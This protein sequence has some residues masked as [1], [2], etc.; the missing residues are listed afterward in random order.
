MEF[1]LASIDIAGA[2]SILSI[3]L[4]LFAYL[5]TLLQYPGEFIKNYYVSMYYKI[6]INILSTIFQ[7]YMICC[8]PAYYLKHIWEDNWLTAIISLFMILIYMA[9]GCRSNDNLYFSDRI[10]KTVHNVS[11]ETRF[12]AVIPIYIILFCAP[13]F[14]W[15][16]PCL[17]IYLLFHWISDIPIIG[18][19]IR[20]FI[21]LVILY[22]LI[23]G[24][25]GLITLISNLVSKIINASN[26]RY[27]QK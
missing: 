25:F 8:M 19:F 20:G 12:I 6:T 26:A 11:V 16:T 2:L 17:W 18:S 4:Y 27:D 3:V 13:Q 7:V 21:C 23:V 24:V 14:I 9:S 15:Q 5:T 22:W 10:D 1:L